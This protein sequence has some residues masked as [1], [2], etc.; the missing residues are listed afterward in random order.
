VRFV[1]ADDI[2]RVLTYPA[3]IDALEEA[4]RADI[5]VPERHVHMIPQPAGRLQG[6][7]RLSRERQDREAVGV[8]QLSADVG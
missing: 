1:T 8:R 4:F 2:H 5:A 6:G 7:Q 3:L